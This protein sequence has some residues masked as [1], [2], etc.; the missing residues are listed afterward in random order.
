MS[1]N[2]FFFEIN[3]TKVRKELRKL[4]L[5]LKGYEKQASRSD[6]RGMCHR[7]FRGAVKES[8]A[9]EGYFRS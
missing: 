3:A 1:R 8:I 6:G 7:D 4:G 9:W 2:D 5:E